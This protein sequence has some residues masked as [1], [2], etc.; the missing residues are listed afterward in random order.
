[1]P[2]ALRWSVAPIITAFFASPRLSVPRRPSHC[3]P[4]DSFQV[5]TLDSND[6]EAV[7]LSMQ[8]ARRILFVSARRSDCKPASPL[9]A[10]CRVARAGRAAELYRLAKYA[11]AGALLMLLLER[12]FEP[13]ST[14]C[15]IARICLLTDR[16]AQAREHAAQAWVARATAE[17]YVV[18]RILWLQLAT[19]YLDERVPA[20]CLS[21][22]ETSRSEFAIAAISPLDL[23]LDTDGF[24]SLATIGELQK[25]RRYAST[26]RLTAIDYLL[27]YARLLRG[28]VRS[29]ARSGSKG[30]LRRGRRRERSPG[31]EL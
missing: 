5:T 6:R 28:C 1:M 12:G 23:W 29:F 26:P 17:P 20:G 14:R 18:P 22:L 21:A 24:L 3:L 11:E 25:C 2:R 7:P 9:P 10:L 31:G 16:I 4:P 15:H 19:T 8:E 30:S 13:A 27:A